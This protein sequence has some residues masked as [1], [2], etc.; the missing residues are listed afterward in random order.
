MPLAGVLTGGPVYCAAA[1]LYLQ[2]TKLQGPT[3]FVG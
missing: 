2:K 3:G 1:P